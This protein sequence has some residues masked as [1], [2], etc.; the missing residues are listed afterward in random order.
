MSRLHE[1]KELFQH[2]TAAWGRGEQAVLVILTDVKGS[3]YR[4]PGTKMVMTSDGRMSGTIS[5]G[6]LESDLFEWAK[7]VFSTK[8]MMIHQYDLSDNE[9][10]SL[11]IGC[12]GNLRF[13]FLP[14]LPCNQF[15]LHVQNLLFREQDFTLLIDLNTG[16]MSLIEENRTLYGD[17]VPASVFTH[18]KLT[19]SRQTRAEIFEKHFYIDAVKRSERLIIA[20]AG[21]DAVPVADLARRA[22]F[23]VTILDA[24]TYLNNKQSFPHAEHLV[25][26]PEDIESNQLI[27][28]WWVIMNHHQMKDEASL[29]LAIESKPRY[30]GVL[31]PIYRTNEIL[32]NIGY[33]VNSGP[34]HSP[35]GLDIGAENSDEVAISIVSE[36]MS[37]RAGRVP[38]LL[39]GKVKIHD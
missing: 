21:R 16:K 4:L 6:C 33:S 38:R 22:G 25:R 34:I 10:W 9:I 20:G 27:D 23:A 36:I 30:I 18:A 19:A 13:L 31:G 2:I 3:A 39:H 35:I 15:W 28:S 17:E 5:G 26:E 1:F 24:R 11:G 32:A 37:V 12:K 14:I 7:H 29:K 8:T